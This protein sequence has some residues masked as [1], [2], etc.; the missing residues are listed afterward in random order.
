MNSVGRSEFVFLDVSL[1]VLLEKTAD[2]GSKGVA[3]LALTG[4]EH[5]VGGV[6]GIDAEV[7]SSTF[8]RTRYKVEAIAGIVQFCLIA[9]FA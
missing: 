5:A 6:N 3:A 2:A 4:V 9:L 8:C 1:V 7:L